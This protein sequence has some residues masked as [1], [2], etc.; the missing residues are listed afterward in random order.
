MSA[1]DPLPLRSAMHRDTPAGSRLNVANAYAL[2]H[3]M[4]REEFVASLDMEALKLQIK[5]IAAYYTDE[6]TKITDKQANVF[7]SRIV[8]VLGEDIE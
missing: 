1:V 8:A 7:M 4:T 5:H 3:L 2:G 6:Y